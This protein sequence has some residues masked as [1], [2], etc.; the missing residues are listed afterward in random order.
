MV[1]L[2]ELLRNKY[3]EK[4]PKY[5]SNR[6]LIEF[7]NESK[8]LIEKENYLELVNF[9][10]KH[11][12]TRRSLFREWE[13]ENRQLLDYKEK[14]KKAKKEFPQEK[15]F[16]ELLAIRQYSR[17]TIKAYTQALRTA[18]E[19]LQNSHNVLISEA[20]R[21]QFYEYFLFLTKERKVSTSTLRIARFSIE[22]YRSELIFQ[23]V[24]LDFAYQLRKKEHLPT[25][26]SK[27]EIIKILNSTNNLKHKLVLSLLYSAG[28]RLSE[29]I[30]L[31]VKDIDLSRKTIFIREGKGGKD[32]ITVL[33]DKLVTDLSIF[34]ENRI[35]KDILFPSN[36]KSDL[37][38]EKPLSARTVQK[39]LSTAL[40]KSG[41]RK[42]GTPHDLRH[43]FATHLLETGTDIRF[44][45]RLLG[46]KNI[47]TTTIYTKLANPNIAGVKSPL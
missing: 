14:I 43:S 6:Q 9:Y 34:M 1:S 32:R 5:I 23:P 20:N 4:F 38:N 18:N 47:S 22:Y 44:I 19:Y 37:G 42:K 24:T 40:L 7:L 8:D 36:Q 12:Q 10:F 41:I 35:G 46:H 16:R 26:F 31:K 11:A 17:K 28:L 27:S 25:I 15:E 21:E 3:G 2:I 29:V 39:I 30:R 45:Q 13:I 33:S